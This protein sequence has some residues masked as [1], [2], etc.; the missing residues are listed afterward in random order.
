MYNIK[1]LHP[2][3][4]AKINLTLIVAI[5]SYFIVKQLFNP[6]P[7]KNIPVFAILILFAY[8]FY[9]ICKA[10]SQKLHLSLIWTEVMGFISILAG[11]LVGAY[12]INITGIATF[13]T[14]DIKDTLLFAFVF[15]TGR[16]LI[17]YNNLKNL[18]LIKQKEAEYAIL[19]EANT[20]SQLEVLYAKINP[21]FLYNALNSIAGLAM[22][23]GKK[24]RDMTVALSKLLR[25]SLNYAE[26]NFATLEAEVEIIKT[27]LEIEKIRFE[28]KLTYTICITEESKSILVPRFLFQPL[29]E[30]SIK[31]S[32]L[33]S[34]NSIFIKMNASVVEGNLV[35]TIHDNGKSFPERI[36]PGYGLK[37]VTDKLQLLFPAKHEL[38]ISNTPQKEITIII[39]DVNNNE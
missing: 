19:K 38:L 13:G 18:A 34:E 24:T 39:K 4:W 12:L 7:L 9:Y 30:N 21:H 28:E 1:K 33:E 37:N 31:H 25:Y 8:N 36:H 17:S 11:T 22:Q 29:V 2:N 35:I 3:Y 5:A 23:D 6:A 32:F 10:V 15:N 14:S 27:Y 20:Q 26:S 16:T